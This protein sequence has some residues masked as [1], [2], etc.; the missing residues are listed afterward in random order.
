MSLFDV[1]RTMDL[2]NTQLAR[3][4]ATH[5]QAVKEGPENNEK[6]DFADTEVPNTQG[7]ATG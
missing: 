6:Y 7:A 2:S 4:L 3:L 5:I 1:K